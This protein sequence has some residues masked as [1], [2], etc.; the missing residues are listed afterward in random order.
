M[1][2][3]LS[4]RDLLSAKLR[5]IGVNSDSA[6]D[7]FSKLQAQ[8]VKTSEVMN[9]MGKSVSSLR[10]KL[11]L[12]RNERDLIPAENIRAIRTYNSEI[13]K[14]EK[15]VTKL[16]TINGSKFKSAMKNAFQSMPGADFI[17]NPIV[18]GAGIITGIAKLGME[19]EQTKVS[20]DVLLGSQQK[21]AD[22]LKQLTVYSNKTPYGKQDIQDASKVMLQFGISAEDIMPNMRMLGDIAMGNADKMQS[23]TLAFSQVS[24]AGK[25]QGE[26]LLQM[27]NAGFNPLKEISR[28]TGESMASLREKMEKGAISAEMVSGAFKTATSEGGLFYGMS[29]KMSKT[30]GGQ[31]S[32][33]I[34]L[35]KEKVLL[36]FSLIQPFIQPTLDFVGYLISGLGFV[37]TPLVSFVN[38]LK[39]GVIWAKIL[40]GMIL[41]IG[42][43]YLLYNLNLKIANLY[44]SRYILLSKLQNSWD[45]ITVFWKNAATVAT[46]A[47]TAA[48]W[49]LNAAFIASP[50]G[51]I[52]LGIGALVG[53]IIWAWNKFEGF[54]NVV[55]S[56]WETIKGFGNILKE[57]VIDRIKGIISGLGAIGS[58]I[59]KLFTGD[60]SGAWQTAKQGLADMSG[61]NAVK[62]VVAAAQNMGN[63][64][65]AQIAGSTSIVPVK[66]PGTR[67][68]AAS[69][70]NRLKAK[71]TTEAVASGGTRNTSIAL[72]IK[73]GLIGNITFTEGLR[74]KRNEFEKAVTESVIRAL[75][76]AQSSA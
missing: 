2:Y 72:T 70:G 22:L 50:I 59:Y 27:I 73:G 30:I 55:L 26:D 53:A 41:A 57:Y 60:F 75:A 66:A 44:M 39:G 52:V 18:A 20:F 43:A 10:D 40:G 42:S 65:A 5:T 33:V 32:T 29:D 14:L 56:V 45:K 74:E 68:P 4:L 3:T 24:S 58:A 6:L 11:S 48:Q 38:A 54:R 49:L 46:T 61:Y 31:L 71:A 7:K 47:W 16:E 9:S 28:T 37:L 23:L 63:A 51:W 35:L 64:S 34:D 17:S 8:A 62:N 15:Q 76:M 13:K 12:L 21:S 19:A 1:E 67:T 25:L 69:E 36:L